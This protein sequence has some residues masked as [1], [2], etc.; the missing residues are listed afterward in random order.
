MNGTPKEGRSQRSLALS[1][2]F[3]VGA[4]IVLT[5]TA[6][7]ASSEQPFRNL[8]V[9]PPYRGSEVSYNYSSVRGC[10]IEKIRVPG[11]FNLHKGVG[12]YSVSATARSCAAYLRNNATAQGGFEALINVPFH[13]GSPYVYANA[14]YAA[15]GNVNFSGGICTPVTGSRFSACER[16]AEVFVDVDAIFEDLTTGYLLDMGTVDVTSNISFDYTHCVASVCKTKAHLRLG[17]I[18]V[19][20]RHVWVYRFINSS[21]VRGDKYAISFTLFGRA[22]VE[23]Y[24]VHNAVLSGF[25]G[26]AALNFATAGNGM[27]LISIV[28]T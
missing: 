11:V 18:A 5:L 21:M 27:N 19:S 20:G 9:T 6:A 22:Q 4:A 8:S 15:T 23:T 2:V 25:S 17:P 3:P 1:F 12:K 28:D 24:Y 7:A 16:W 14:T 26:S 10:A 13:V